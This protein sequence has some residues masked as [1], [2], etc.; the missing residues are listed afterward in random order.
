MSFS[1]YK[2]NAHTIPGPPPQV[3][4][5]SVQAPSDVSDVFGEAYMDQRLHRAALGGPHAG[6]LLV[7]REEGRCSLEAGR[8]GVGGHLGLRVEVVDLAAPVLRVLLPRA[9]RLLELPRLAIGH[10]LLGRLLAVDH[11]LLL[12]LD[13]GLDRGLL[14]RDRRLLRARA[15]LLLLLLDLLAR[16]LGLGLGRGLGLL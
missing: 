4:V 15:I 13:L 8:L 16:G 11:R 2:V 7:I 12:R 10:L 3:T 6:R 9:R 5:S 14:L 1:S